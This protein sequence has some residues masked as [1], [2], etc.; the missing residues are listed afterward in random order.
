MLEIARRAAQ[1][2]L[3]QEIRLLFWETTTGCNLECIHCRR[4]EVSRELSKQDMTTHQAFIFID[5]LAEI[6]NPVLV[7]SGGEPLYRPDIFAIALHARERGL[8]VALSTNGTLVNKDVAKHIVDAGIRRVSISIDGAD[9]TTHDDFRK[10]DGSLERALEGFRNLKERGM[11]MQINCTVTKHNVHQLQQ[12]YD[13]AL[14]M[15][16]DALHFFMLVPVGCGVQIAES[17]QLSSEQ[18]ENVLRWIYDKSREA[19]IFMRATC[20]PHY[21]RIM[22]QEAK[23]FGEQVAAHANGMES[24]TRGCLAGTSVCFVSHK[25]SVFPCGYLPVSCGNVLESS[26]KEIWERAEPFQKLRETENLEGK[27]GFCE[28][29]NVC[30]GCRARAYYDTGNYLAQEPTCIYQPSNGKQGK[31]LVLS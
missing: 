9:Q 17:N 14:G 30:L 1:V 4:L 5:Q 15:G 23:K 11:S 27:C 19:K 6:G 7:L 13:L 28:F 2:Q 10:Q 8:P 16:A 22:R 25:G 18:Y 24:L 29:K 26:F 20:A 12:L 3:P 21:F 31:R